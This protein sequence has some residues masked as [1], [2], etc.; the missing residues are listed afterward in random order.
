MIA[1]SDSGWKHLL[2]P[3]LTFKAVKWRTH[4]AVVALTELKLHRFIKHNKEDSVYTVGCLKHL[5]YFTLVTDLQ[6]NHSCFWSTKWWFNKSKTVLHTTAY[7]GTFACGKCCTT[8]LQKKNVSIVQSEL[9]IRV[10]NTMKHLLSLLHSFANQF[11]EVRPFCADYNKNNPH[12][13]SRCDMQ[14]FCSRLILLHCEGNSWWL[15]AMDEGRWLHNRGLIWFQK[16]AWDHNISI[17]PH[18]AQQW[19]PSLKWM[20]EGFRP[21]PQ[22]MH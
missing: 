5:N 2:V 18:L 1:F 9:N 20:S 3:V 7:S 19:H 21:P 10:V 17:F 8:A 16:G 22:M 14:A 13:L 11:W 15:W 6:T 4:T 12:L